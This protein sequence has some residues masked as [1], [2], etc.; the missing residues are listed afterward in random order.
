[1]LTVSCTRSSSDPTTSVPERSTTTTTTFVPPT[2]VP[3]AP[4]GQ[5]VVQRFPI[6]SSVP[7]KL[8]VSA[9]AISQTVSIRVGS[10]PDQAQHWVT[11]DV[12]P[13]PGGGT[14]TS[15]TEEAPLGAGER[16][17][18]TRA[19]A[20]R[21]RFATSPAG[22]SDGRQDH[23]FQQYD[24]VEDGVAVTVEAYDTS[25]HE[26]DERL[27]A[28]ALVDRRGFDDFLRSHDADLVC[29]N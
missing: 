19:G 20:R 25:Q 8:V 1:M 10:P 7:P 22:G 2:G 18:R 9:Q 26:V 24:W 29:R 28:L 3:E 13:F 4:V 11:V 6:L 16:L 23:V 14:G 15:P 12:K 17:V 21:A 27:A 5:C